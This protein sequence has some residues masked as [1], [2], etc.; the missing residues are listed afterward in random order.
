LGAGI[1]LAW[2]HRERLAFLRDLSRAYL[3]GRQ[4]YHQYDHVA[5]DIAF[6]PE[7]APRLDVYS[8][9]DGEGHP[10][11][12]FLHGGAWSSYHKGL[13]APVAMRMLPQEIVVVIPDYSL[14]PGAHY[15]QMTSEVAAAMAWTLENIGD[16]GGDSGRVV[17]AGHSAGAHLLGLAAMDR[18]FLSVHGHSSEEL[19][20]LIGLSAVYDVQAEYDFWL[21]KGSTP[22]LITGVFQGEEN[23]QRAS[24][25]QHVRAGLPPWLVIHG[26][27]DESVP[28]EMS[29]EFA[30]AL[31]AVGAPVEL[32]V[33]SGAAHSDYLFEGLR[34]ERAPVL[35]DIV[36]FVHGCE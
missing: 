17:V 30:E 10:V 33:Y 3:E 19:C 35:G 22:R 36:S 21:A 15:E 32:R 7:M 26:D 14:F 5:R 31:E 27:Q 23:F 25:I 34:D 29:I 18:R 2:T 11:L 16:Y 8:P 9:P 28:V 13:F 1:S 12:I 6:H 4:F 24:P 20:G